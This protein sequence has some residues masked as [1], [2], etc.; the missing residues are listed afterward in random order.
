MRR[1]LAF[2]L[3]ALHA[4][5]VLGSEVLTRVIPVAGSTPGNQGSFFR[6][7][8][9]LRNGGGAA[10]TGRFVFHPNGRSALG[11]DPS[12]AFT[13]PSDETQAWDDV[14]DAMGISGLGSVDVMIAAASS[15]PVIVT[16]VYN[17]AGAEGTSGFTEEALDPLDKSAATAVVGAGKTGI[18]VAPADL[19]KYRFNIGLRTLSTGVG[20][21]LW[22][23]RPDGTVSHGELRSY[24]PNF[25]EQLSADEFAN[26]AIEE[27]D[28]IEIVVERGSVIMY[29]A[30]TDNTTNDPSF[31]YARVV[32]RT[33]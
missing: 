22:V 21:M 24:N 18:L 10:I 25:F 5:T 27:N 11:N 19:T 8:L 30:T 7:A 17:D 13:V 28:S 3:I 29:G 1:A 26:V 23:R 15:S 6:T 4:V 31:Q 16:R 12:L 33:N 9:Q 2:V 20:F 32:T 14:V